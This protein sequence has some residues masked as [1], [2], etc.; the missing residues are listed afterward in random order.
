MAIVFKFCLLIRKFI[1]SL[2]NPILDWVSVL[3]WLVE[4]QFYRAKVR[5]FIYIQDALSSSVK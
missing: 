1:L 5:S 3:G 4:I 2:D